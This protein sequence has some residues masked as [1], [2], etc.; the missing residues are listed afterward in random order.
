MKILTLRLLGVSQR[1]ELKQAITK[2]LKFLLSAEVLRLCTFLSFVPLMHIM[3]TTR[4]QNSTLISLRALALGAIPA[5]L[6][7]SILRVQLVKQQL[8]AL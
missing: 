6:H 3:T 1:L 4:R 2:P 8:T 5:G 7:L